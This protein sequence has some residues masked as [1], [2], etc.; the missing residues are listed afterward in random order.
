MITARHV[1]GAGNDIHRG[2]TLHP[3]PTPVTA[4]ARPA[5]PGP[6]GERVPEAVNAHALPPARK[7]TTG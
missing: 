7:E 3:H 4:H 5:R 2:T 1:P 6:A